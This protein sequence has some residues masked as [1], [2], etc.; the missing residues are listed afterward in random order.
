VQSQ[1]GIKLSLIMNENTRFIVG[2]WVVVGLVFL[3]LFG[4]ML[5]GIVLAFQ[6]GEG[7]R[8]LLILALLAGGVLLG[9]GMWRSKRR[10]V[11]R[12]IRRLLQSPSPDDLIAYFHDNYSRAASRLIPEADTFVTQG[13]ATAYAYYGAFDK[14]RAVLDEIDWGSRLPLVRAGGLCSEA[15]LC[16]LGT[17]NYERGLAFA[18]QAQR[19]AEMSPA[20][21]GAQTA[22]TV[23]AMWI[24]VG[25]ILCGS[26]SAETVRSL[27]EKLTKLPVTAEV[28]IAWGLA[29][30]YHKMK[31]P[32]KAEA[33]ENLLKEIAP[34]CRGLAL[35]PLVKEQ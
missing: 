23:G 1:S 16:Y 11:E 13:C 15:L 2:L 12:R 24:E 5:Y 29:V 26:P 20:L 8:A 3:F 4:P 9:F 7:L 14:A 22:A 10:S 17:R 33:M 35:P 28:L 31:Q 6:Q 19:L 18:R 25:E 30:A 34:H 32:A 21:P 27:E